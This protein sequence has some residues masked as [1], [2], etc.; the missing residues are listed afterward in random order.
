MLISDERI[1]EE[2][3]ISR[4]SPGDLYLKNDRRVTRWNGVHIFYRS[5]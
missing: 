3:E 2:K 4:K 1:P 5:S